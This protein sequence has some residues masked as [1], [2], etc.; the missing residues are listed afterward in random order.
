V[1]VVIPYRGTD[2]ELDALLVGMSVLRL[3]PGDSMV[4][5]DNGP[6]GRAAREL[7][8]RRSVIVETA[9]AS[10][11]YARNRG[12]SRGHADWILFLDADVR[13]PADLLDRYFESPPGERDGLLA[14][15]VVDEV[16]DFADW[17]HPAA[18]FAHLKAAMSQ[19]NTLDGGEWAYAQTANCAVRRAGFEAI[20]GFTEDI[21]SGG[22]ADLCFR[23]RRAGWALQARDG[24]AVVHRS[25]RTLRSILRQR[26]RHG[27]G[28]RWLD[29]VYPG[30]FPPDLSLGT[31]RWSVSQAAGAARALLRRDGDRAILLAVGVL[32]QWAFELGRLAP[33]HVSHRAGRVD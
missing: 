12:A 21:R 15:A 31:I 28:A 18:R 17:R 19:D 24:A 13:P 22:D 7:G 1:D 8:E 9:V 33:N 32:W 29:S 27:S 11:Y 20:G 30:A 16:V 26:A 23:M 3:D 5:V 10:S 25:R 4:V 14:G 6:A 2:A